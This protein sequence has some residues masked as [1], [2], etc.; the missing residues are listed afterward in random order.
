[1]GRKAAAAARAPWPGP[2]INQ[3]NP[4]YEGGIAPHCTIKPRYC[5]CTRNGRTVKCDVGR[6]G[7]YRLCDPSEAQPI[8]VREGTLESYEA[9]ERAEQKKRQN[10]L[11]G[12]QRFVC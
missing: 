10:R 1:M 12:F 9:V 8:R 2:K 6:N 11:H 7:Q 4:S 5:Y 3:C